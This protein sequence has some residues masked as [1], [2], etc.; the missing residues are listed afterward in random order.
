MSL[1]L[2]EPINVC[3]ISAKQLIKERISV[4]APRRSWI[5]QVQ[6]FSECVGWENM[7]G[8][9]IATT[10]ARTRAHKAAPLATQTWNQ[11]PSPVSFPKY[12]NYHRRRNFPGESLWPVWPLHQ[13][14][15]WTVWSPWSPQ[16]SQFPWHVTWQRKV[17]L[18]NPMAHMKSEWTGASVVPWN[19][20]SSPKKVTNVAEYLVLTSTSLCATSP[21]T[22]FKDSL[23]WEL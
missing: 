16:C 9:E 19:K 20:D 1:S 4:K 2:Q 3:I 22:W 11:T 21:L 18:F 13:A 7:R 15:S 12:H 8:L 5:P 10:A 14:D 17:R 6:H 23:P